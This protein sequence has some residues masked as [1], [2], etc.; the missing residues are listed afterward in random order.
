MVFGER[1]E[2]G[3]EGMVNYLLHTYYHYR[4]KETYLSI[5]SRP[6]VRYDDM[7]AKDES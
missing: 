4:G 1:S 3:R 5:R 6:R 2:E 7:N